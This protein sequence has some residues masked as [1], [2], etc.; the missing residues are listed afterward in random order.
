MLVAFGLR[1]VAHI[2]FTEL[3]MAAAPLLA[4]AAYKEWKASRKWAKKRR[5]PKRRPTKR[6]K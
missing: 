4:L 3:A 6:R 5:P 1:R 2:F